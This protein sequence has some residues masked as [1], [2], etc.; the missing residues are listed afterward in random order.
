MNSLTPVAP[1]FL[2]WLAVC[3]LFVVL[4]PIALGIWASHR[5]HVRWRYFLFGAAVFLVFQILTRLPALRVLDPMVEPRLG[6]SSILTWTWLVGLSLSAAL[7]EEVGRYVGFRVFMRREEKT[8]AKAVMYGLGHGGLESML[9]VGGT[10]LLSLISLLSIQV[11][12]LGQVPAEQ[13]AATVQQIQTLASQ[14]VWLSL[15]GAW[16]RLWTLPIQVACSVLVLQVFRRGSLVWLW[17]AIAAHTLVDLTTVGLGQALG[18]SVSTSLIVEAAIAG[19]GA[20]AVWLIWRMRAG[21]ESVP[22][23]P[24]P[25][26]ADAEMAAV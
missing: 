8:W 11:G 14:P 2:L 17:L 23:A 9:L 10:G 15:L 26:H 3:T 13:R 22:A 21:G 20:V 6:A 19:F 1:A 18:A 4:Y 5:L 24:V 12:G 25:A 7:F 16:E